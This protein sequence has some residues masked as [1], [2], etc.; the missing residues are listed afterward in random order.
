M[1][2]AQRQRRRSLTA[3][4]TPCASAFNFIASLTTFLGISTVRGIWS[5]PRPRWLDGDDGHR[6]P[7]TCGRRARVDRDATG[8]R[9][10][11]LSAPDQ[12]R[13]HARK[14]STALQFVRADTREISCLW[15]IRRGLLRQLQR[16]YKAANPLRFKWERVL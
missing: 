8:S 1:I 15:R 10:L 14:R 16:P 13:P 11:L 6:P 4:P 3:P 12:G 7:I 5:A 2:A 9:M